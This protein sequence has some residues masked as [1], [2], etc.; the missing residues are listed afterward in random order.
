MITLA[1]RS[2]RVSARSRENLIFI[3]PLLMLATV[4]LATG[5][6]RMLGPWE[7]LADGAGLLLIAA[8]LWVRVCARQWKAEHSHFSL[9][10]NGLYAYMRHPLYAGSFLLGTG[11]CLLLGDLLVLVAFTAAF[12]LSHGA[13][14]RRE[15]AELEQVFGEEYREYCRCVG[16]L[17]PRRTAVRTAVAPKRL[18]EGVVREADAVCVGLALPL[19]VG[20]GSWAMKPHDAG[21]LQTAAPILWVAGFGAVVGLWASLKRAYRPLIQAERRRHLIV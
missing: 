2:P 13:V 12:W 1:R 19:L 8:G 9:V 21:L 15:E 16:G 20:L 14:I 17:L 5:S 6:F 11:L 10:T 7:P 4:R 18:G 3:V